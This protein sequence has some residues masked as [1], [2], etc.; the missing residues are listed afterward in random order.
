MERRRS[1]RGG[2]GGRA[3]VSVSAEP[4][5]PL[6]IASLLRGRARGEAAPPFLASLPFRGPQPATPV[7][8]S[9]EICSKGRYEF[10]PHAVS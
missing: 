7:L 9:V 8:L 3:D 2:G 6:V 10:T 5:M 4:A 1:R